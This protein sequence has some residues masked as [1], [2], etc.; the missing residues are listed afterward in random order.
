[1]HPEYL[2][3]A[4]VRLILRLWARQRQAAGGGLVPPVEGGLLVWP[5]YL[6]NAFAVLDDTAYRLEEARRREAEARRKRR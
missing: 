1:M 2:V 4:E 6:V 3:D 5:A